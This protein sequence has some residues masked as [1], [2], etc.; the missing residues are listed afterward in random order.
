MENIA[1]EEKKRFTHISA[2]SVERRDSKL[3]SKV[4]LR[5]NIWKESSSPATCAKNYSDPEQTL[6]HTKETT[7]L[8]QN[9]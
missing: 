5:Q 6:E 2:R 8:L 9:R 7:T 1:M 3:Q 4:T